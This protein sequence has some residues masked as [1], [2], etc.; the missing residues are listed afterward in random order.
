MEYNK[1]IFLSAA[2]SD[3]Y[4]CWQ[5]E[6]FLDNNIDQGIDN[7]THLLWFLPHDR[8]DIGWEPALAKL[9]AKY[10]DQPQIKFFFFEDTEDILNKDIRKINYI[11]LLRPYCLREHFK[12]NQWLSKENIFYHDADILLVRPIDF[13]S[14]D[15]DA[16]TCYLSYTGARFKGGNYLDIDY[17]QGKEEQAITELKEELKRMDVISIMAEFCNTTKEDVIANNN[18][19]GGAQYL[20][21]NIDYEFWDDVYN[22]CKKLRPFLMNVN[23]E[24]FK[25]RSS[26]ERENNG[27]QSFCTDM[28]AVL[29]NIWA[30][31]MKTECPS[32]LDFAWATDPIE[33]L[34][35]VNIFHNAGVS[36]PVMNLNGQDEIMFW[37][38]AYANNDRI[39]YLEK[40]KLML[41]TD[42]YCT[43]FYTNKL[44]TLRNTIF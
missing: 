23:Q 11:P 39:P 26:G 38:G 41:V 20:L 37:K 42:K 12:N 9:K 17:L 13:Q 34:E 10:K 1:P 33:K 2:P 15:K 29:Y 18:G 36:S 31:G 19:V 22:S 40:D 28:W 35:T 27:Y 25:G 5:V 32:E 4:F 14:I 21:K 8:L 43:S 6:L 24:F 44:L 3:A 30:R 16:N 7:E